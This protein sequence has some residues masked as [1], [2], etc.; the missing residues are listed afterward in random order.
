M[1]AVFIAAVSVYDTL[2][3]FEFREGIMEE[4]PFCRY[5]I[6]LDPDTLV[7]FL[8]GKLLGTSSVLICLV[9]ISLFRPIWSVVVT[10]ALVI[11][12]SSL[13]CYLQVV[14]TYSVS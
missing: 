11:F 6:Q 13:L 5:L 8:A 12:Q 14:D 3:V 7:F 1:G 10:T 4:N 2:L 9:W